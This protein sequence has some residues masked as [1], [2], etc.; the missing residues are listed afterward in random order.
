MKTMTIKT[1]TVT[2][3]TTIKTILVPDDISELD[4]IEPTDALKR[5]LSAK[6]GHDESL[7]ALAVP[8][9]Q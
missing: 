4:L 2:T 5:H 6:D 3:T 8:A 7:S 1:T 9:L